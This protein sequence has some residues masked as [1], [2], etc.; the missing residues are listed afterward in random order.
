[1][2][3]KHSQY[4]SFSSLK[5]FFALL[6]IIPVLSVVGAG[7]RMGGFGGFHRVYTFGWYDA[8]SFLLLVPSRTG[9]SRVQMVWPGSPSSLKTQPRLAQAGV[10][11]HRAC[12]QPWSASQSFIYLPSSHWEQQN[13]GLVHK[14]ISVNL[15]IG[16]MNCGKGEEPKWRH[17]G[18]SD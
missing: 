18:Y 14:F 4:S 11:F 10:Y 13:K 15:F 8:R 5:S 6:K 7:D 17:W 16:N 1:M 3:G 9:R 12:W 2:V